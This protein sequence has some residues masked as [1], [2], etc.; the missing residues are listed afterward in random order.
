MAWLFIDPPFKNV[1]IQSVKLFVTKYDAQEENLSD[2]SGRYPS[3]TCKT[4]FVN[5]STKII[6]LCLRCN[7]IFSL[8]SHIIFSASPA[9]SSR[10][11]SAFPCHLT[12]EQ[13]LTKQQGC[14]GNITLPLMTRRLRWNK[15]GC[16]LGCKSVYL[17][18]FRKVIQTEGK[19]LIWIY[20]SLYKHSV[21]F[22]LSHFC[23]LWSEFCIIDARRSSD[24]NYINYVC[25][26]QVVEG[27]FT[28]LYCTCIKRSSWFIY[29][30]NTNISDPL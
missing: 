23:F 2:L 5:K 27:V 22:S 7:S 8:L 1:L 6:K 29:V 28:S 17:Q 11:P 25:G 26:E 13:S 20:A 15:Y 16:Q 30:Y 24:A 18:I 19:R 12:A 4:N 9:F 3:F 21:S 10:L 14:Y